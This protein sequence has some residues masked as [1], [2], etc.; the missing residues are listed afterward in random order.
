MSASVTPARIAPGSAAEVGWGT[1][2]FARAAGLVTGTEPPRLFLT[3]GKHRP[4]FTGWLHFAGRLMPGGSLS[5][6]ESECIILRVAHLC[7]SQYEF[8]HHVRLGRRAGVTRRDV[9][10]LRVGPS[11]SGWSVRA[12]TILSAVDALHE[13]RDLDDSMWSA[14]RAYFDERQAIEFCLLVGHYEMLAMT[15]TTLRVQ[16]DAKR[17]ARWS[18]GR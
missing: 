1:W 3:L 18:S 14:L 6:F 15:L 9:E 17:A 13:Q 5:R 2:L 8:D 4:L 7:G 10:R 11:A 12:R 16:P